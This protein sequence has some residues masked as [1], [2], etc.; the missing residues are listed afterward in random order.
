MA[1]SIGPSDRKRTLEV[2]GILGENFPPS[3]EPLAIWITLSSTRGKIDLESLLDP[4][5]VADFWRAVVGRVARLVVIVCKSALALGISFSEADTAR[6][7]RCSRLVLRTRRGPV[8]GCSENS[9]LG[10]MCLTGRE[11][12]EESR[13]STS[14]P[15]LLVRERVMGRRAGGVTDLGG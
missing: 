5:A 3:S 9:A 10:A 2:E 1:R 7:D 15:S 6:G 11:V 12:E 13:T 8:S 14:E 4:L